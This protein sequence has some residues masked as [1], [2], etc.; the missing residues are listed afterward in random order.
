MGGCKCP[1]HGKAIFVRQ[2]D[3]VT[4]FIQRRLAAVARFLPNGNKAEPVQGPRRPAPLDE[5]LAR[6]GHVVCFGKGVHPAPAKAGLH[7]GLYY[8]NLCGHTWPHRRR[9]AVVAMGPCPGSYVWNQAIPDHL[10][11]PW[12]MPRGQ[13]VPLVWRGSPVHLSH[14]L[15]FYRGCLFCRTCGARSAR[16][17]SPA[18]VAPCLLRPMSVSTQR[19]LRCMK[20]GWWPDAGE[21]WPEPP[22]TQPPG[23]LVP[24]LE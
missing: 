2:V 13:T 15:Q 1:Q 16:A 18:L 19:R 7:G 23:D 20:R 14:Q 21:T 10:S 5:A 4:W 3:N 17:M 9:L 8:C 11:R 24:F 22:G 12:L 6:L